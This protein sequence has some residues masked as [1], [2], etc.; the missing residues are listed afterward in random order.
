MEN[1]PML[2]LAEFKGALA[3]RRGI[4]L[5]RHTLTRYLNNGLVAGAIMGRDES[6]VRR[7]WRIP[8]SAVD[9]FKLVPR[10]N[11]KLRG[12]ER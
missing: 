5:S 6:G 10:G 8:E 11:P 1:E 12:Q 2:T 4:H 7:A 3:A 9:R